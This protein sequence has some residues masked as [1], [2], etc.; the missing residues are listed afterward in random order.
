MSIEDIARLV[1]QVWTF[2]AIC[3]ALFSMWNVPVLA[4]FVGH[5][6]VQFYDRRFDA[7]VTLPTH[8]MLH[9]FCICYFGLLLPL[10]F[11]LGV[12]TRHELGMWQLGPHTNNRLTIVLGALCMMWLLAHCLEGLLRRGRPRFGPGRT[13]RIMGGLALALCVWFHVSTTVAMWQYAA[14]EFF[15]QLGDWAWLVGLLQSALYIGYPQSCFL[16][17]TLVYGLAFREAMFAR[18]TPQAPPDIQRRWRAAV[19]WAVGVLLLMFAPFWLSIPRVTNRQALKLLVKHHDQ[20]VETAQLAEL[21]PALLAGIVYVAQTRDHPRWTGDFIEEL[22]VALWDKEGGMGLPSVFDAPLLDTSAGLCQ[23]QPSTA[24]ITSFFLG[25]EQTSYRPKLLRKQAEQQFN[26]T[27][28]YWRNWQ[29]LQPQTGPPPPAGQKPI[30]PPGLASRL[31][32]AR[33]N[34]RPMEKLLLDPETNLALAAVILRLYQAHW[35]EN[36][37][38]L[39]DRP[40]ILATLYNI[41]YT[42]SFPKAEPRANDFGKRV[43]RFMKSKECD[44]LFP[45]FKGGDNGQNP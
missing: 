22:G 8:V 4:L 13:D 10:Y 35:R 36:G 24:V 28:R 45:T 11:F 21:E 40:E 43:L 27:R 3:L 14:D 34:Q 5:R 9:Y 15:K 20:I 23:I 6:A 38:P 42:R 44:T 16:G 30:A 29:H 33:P 19:P 31:A 39:D 26:R 12:R 1:I 41:G 18:F 37:F 17:A 2:A 32:P 25:S 7:R